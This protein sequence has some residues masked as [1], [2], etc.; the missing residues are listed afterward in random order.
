MKKYNFLHYI[1][2]LLPI[3]LLLNDLLIY[4]NYLFLS[5]AILY[6]GLFYFL[7][8]VNSVAPYYLAIPIFYFIEVTWPNSRSI[9]IFSFFIIILFFIIKKSINIY[10]ALSLKKIKGFIISPLG[11]GIIIAFILFLLF[12][13]F[14]YRLIT[15]IPQTHIHAISIK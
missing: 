8:Q 6:A 5:F 11:I 2:L 13:T 1:I 4:K 7:M 3:V 14:F 10:G 12:L 15:A 9:L